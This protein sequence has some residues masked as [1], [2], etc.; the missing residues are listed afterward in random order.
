MKLM[1]KNAE[2]RYQSAWGLKADLE[3]CLRHLETTGEIATFGLD[4][5]RNSQSLC[6]TVFYSYSNAHK[7]LLT[8]TTE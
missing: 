8:Y 5:S 2:Q 4:I 7:V 6:K 1:A 3:D